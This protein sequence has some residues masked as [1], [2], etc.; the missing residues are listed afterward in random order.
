M[1]QYNSQEYEDDEK[2]E[3]SN[4]L[5]ESLK[6]GKGSPDLTWRDSVPQIIASCMAYCVVI[7]AG[8]NMAYSTVL[9]GNLQS[10]KDEIKINDDQAS[11]IASL[12]TISLPLGSLLSGPLVDR[13]GRKTVCIM[14][15]VP[16]TLSWLLLTFSH[17][18]AIIYTAR[19]IAGISAGMSTASIVY[20]IE[21][22]H[23]N[24]RAMMLCLNSVFVSLGILITCVLAL[25]LN[26]RKIAMVFTALNTSFLFLLFIIPESP[27]WL[28]C[29]D[30][31][32]D[33]STDESANQT[34]DHGGNQVV[35]QS[36][37]QELN[38]ALAESIDE[39][40]KS[41]SQV[42]DQAL[43]DFLH[44]SLNESSSEVPSDSPDQVLH[45]SVKQAL[46]KLLYQ[47]QN[48]SRNIIP[49]ASPNQ[50]PND[51][52]N[53]VL[54][55]LRNRVLNQLLN[56]SQNESPNQVR[57]QALDL[58]T[59]NSLNQVLSQVQSQAL[60]QSPKA[61]QNE[62]PNQVHNQPLDELLTQS[63]H[64][65][66][67]DKS[68]QER[69]QVLNQALTHLLN[70]AL[71][72]QNNL[73]N[74]VPND[75]QN[76]S[77]NQ[78]PNHLPKPLTPS[79]RLKTHRR[80]RAER[81][82]HWLNPRDHIYHQEL[83]RI[84]DANLSKPKMADEAEGS[85]KG[86]LRSYIEALKS[87]TVYKPICLLLVILLVQQL[88]GAYVVIFYGISVFRE[89]GGTFGNGLNEYGALV[90]L[91]IIRF[92]M[93]IIT[94]VLSRKIGRRVLSITSGL[95]MAFSM[96]FSAM[97]IFLTSVCGEATDDEGGEHG[98]GQQKWMLLV[99]VLFYVCMS[100][101]GFVVIPWSLIG[102]LLPISFRGVGG[103]IMVSVAY[104]IMFG[105]VKSYPFALKTMGAQNVFFG[106]SVVSLIGTAVVYLFL[107]ETLGKSLK[108]IEE[109]FE[110]SGRK[111]SGGRK[112][113]DGKV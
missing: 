102:E 107:P 112:E 37:N 74:Q 105:V 38:Q 9:V 55:Q 84:E 46:D 23:P 108:E 90:L 76:K 68:H 69:D 87:P 14:T 42:V 4:F 58:A 86:S 96:F 33:Q 6:R 57:N 88:S 51:S 25:F 18:L 36:E 48:E 35:K 97:L 92:I 95:G 41:S 65:T 54:I 15:C 79:N 98:V 70:Q 39:S 60:N 20:V 93:S 2:F 29:F 59:N 26:W 64:Q 8:A 110:G 17:S 21:I 71:N 82:L 106:F 22:T 16:S 104:V 5:P 62:S 31:Q 32:S 34:L 49:N 72:H 85:Q 3:T 10:Q 63:P 13:F 61:L 12:V 27:Y 66:T 83:N 47:W 1:D 103:G 24:I 77:P 109:Y 30:N 45:Q 99:I 73:P 28:I 80:R 113:R 67:N 52:L 11:W 7:Q 53:Q 56:D 111:A 40:V 89:I 75:S 78:A 44:Q 50:A 19:V 100:S 94:S 81:Y 91:G 101:L 43:I